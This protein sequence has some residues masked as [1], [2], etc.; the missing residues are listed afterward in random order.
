M[1]F[2]PY[3]DEPE[4]RADLVHEEVGLLEGGEVTPL[5][6]GSGD[7]DIDRVGHLLRTLVS[8]G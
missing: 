4:E 3:S 8:G 7:R 2:D 1:S 6:D 5:I